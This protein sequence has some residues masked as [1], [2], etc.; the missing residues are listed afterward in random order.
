MKYEIIETPF[1]CSLFQDYVKSAQARY[2]A[3]FE[4]VSNSFVCIYRYCTALSN[5]YGTYLLM[6]VLMTLALWV[7]LIEW[8]PNDNFV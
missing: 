3:T 5:S 1:S 2:K 6:W 4:K 7:L 8:Y